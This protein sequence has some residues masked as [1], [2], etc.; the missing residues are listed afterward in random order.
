M[1]TKSGPKQKPAAGL[2]EIRR[3]GRDG[4]GAVTVICRHSLVHFP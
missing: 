1:V 4:Q 2:G 3:H